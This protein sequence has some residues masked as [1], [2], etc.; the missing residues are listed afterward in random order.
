MDFHVYI[1]FIVC[2]LPIFRNSDSRQIKNNIKYPL[3]RERYKTLLRISIPNWELM[4]QASNVPRKIEFPK[5]KGI[6][7]IWSL[8]DS[9]LQRIWDF[10]WK[11][12]PP[13][14]SCPN[15]CEAPLFQLLKQDVGL[16]CSLCVLELA[17]ACFLIYLLLNQF[18]WLPNPQII[19]L[20]DS[21]GLQPIPHSIKKKKKQDLMQLRP[22]HNHSAQNHFIHCLD[23]VG[24]LGRS[25]SWRFNWS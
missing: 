4:P 25:Q 2:I 7:A 11:S 19:T 3:L 17:M 13:D 20:G 15:S 22:V 9:V 23:L 24:C 12:P 21:I 8:G 18:K 1:F 14:S 16:T 10:Q 6:W 5:T